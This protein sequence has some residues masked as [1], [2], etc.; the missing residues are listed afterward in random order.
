MSDVAE[1]VKKIVVE[2]LNVD[3]DKVTDD[4]SF[5]E[6]LGRRQPRHR[7]AGHGLRGRVRDRNSRRCGRII[8][9]VGDAIKFIDKNQ[10]L[11]A[12]S[13][14]ACRRRPAV[15][16]PSNGSK[17][18][19]REDHAKR[20]RR[21]VITGLGLVTPLGCGVETTWSRLIAGRSG[22]ARRST[23]SRSTICPAGSPATCRA[24]TARTARS[25][26]IRLGGSEGAAPGRRVHHLRHDRGDPGGER[27]G[28]RADRLTKIA[29][30]PA[31]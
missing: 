5:I 11:D 1:R 23:S 4:A 7:R 24:A 20:M 17:S 3:A 21:V 13:R 27:C 16:L 19:S 8:V 9:T 10:P 6:D 31:S 26:P 2:H 18:V 30:A 25:I 28:L 14:G 15:N 22:A 29:S 12:T